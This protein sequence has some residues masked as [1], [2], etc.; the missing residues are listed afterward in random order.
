MSIWKDAVFVGTAGGFLMR[1]DIDV[2]TDE[3]SAIP[4]SVS[5]PSK[6]PT[7]AEKKKWTSSLRPPISIIPEF[8]I[9]RVRIGAEADVRKYHKAKSTAS[10]A[11]LQMCPSLGVIFALAEGHLC[12][13]DMRN[14]QFQQRIQPPTNGSID[15]FAI[16]P[17]AQSSAAANFPAVFP[18]AAS[19]T[20]ATPQNSAFTVIS[21]C[22]C[23]GKRIF[24]LSR[25]T[26][27]TAA[28]WSKQ[29]ELFIPEPAQAV[30][31][32]DAVHV[33]VAFKEEYNVI[34]T[35]TG[36]VV[37]L[38]RIDS[39]VP[40]LHSL[41]G[42]RTLLNIGPKSVVHTMDGA[43]THVLTDAI[44][45]HTAP[46]ALGSTSS[47]ALAVDGAHVHV[48]QKPMPHANILSWRTVQNVSVSNAT[49]LC[50]D[51]GPLVLLAKSSQ[52]YFFQPIRASDKQKDALMLFNIH[53]HFIAPPPMTAPAAPTSAT[54]SAPS[55]LSAGAWTAEEA[56]NS[57]TSHLTS[58]LAGTSHPFMLMIHG[59]VQLFRK[60]AAQKAATAVAQEGEKKGPATSAASP[61]PGPALTA[62]SRSELVE[63]VRN[64]QNYVKGCMRILW[65]ECFNIPTPKPTEEKSKQQSGSS[66]PSADSSIAPD[67]LA[68]CSRLFEE[69]L[70]R[71]LHPLLFPY[72]IAA[73]AT[74]D[75]TFV[76]SCAQYLE[77]HVTPET[78]GSSLLK[79]SLRLNRK[80]SVSQ[81]GSDLDVL[82]SSLPGADTT[83]SPHDLPLP[84]SSSFHPLSPN[85][86]L[87]KAIE[88]TGPLYL[89]PGTPLESTREEPEESPPESPHEDRFTAVGSAPAHLLVTSAIAATA[90]VA[91]SN[92]A[93]APSSAATMT[94]RVLSTLLAD[95]FHPS[96]SLLKLLPA[97]SSPLQ[98]LKLL[99]GVHSQLEYD[100]QNVFDPTRSKLFVMSADE[101]LPIFC[102][103]LVH[104]KLQHAF[105]ESE[106]LGDFLDAD[107]QRG[108]HGYVTTT[109]QIAV[110]QLGNKGRPQQLEQWQE[111]FGDGPAA[112]GETGD[113]S[114]TRPDKA[115][116]FSALTAQAGAANIFSQDKE[117]EKS[118]PMSPLV[119]LISPAPGVVRINNRVPIAASAGSSSAGTGGA[120]STPPPSSSSPPLPQSRFG[121]LSPECGAAEGAN[122]ALASP[123]LQRAGSL[124]SLLP[125]AAGTTTPPPSGLAPSSR[126]IGSGIGSALLSGAS[127][128]SPSRKT[129][130]SF[131][132]SVHASANVGSGAIRT[133]SSPIAVLSTTGPNGGQSFPTAASATP[134]AAVGGATPAVRSLASPS[135]S[136][137][138][139]LVGSEEGKP[140]LAMEMKDL[141]HAGADSGRNPSSGSPPVAALAAATPPTGLDLASKRPSVSAAAATAANPNTLIGRS[142]NMLLS[143]ATKAAAAQAAAA[144]NGGTTQN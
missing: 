37:F 47:F 71:R 127:I 125:S 19:S 101:L 63:L 82:S 119:P 24:L 45:Y 2:W 29:Q 120:F 109:F 94:P 115:T 107:A 100:A 66:S 18:S 112:D 88:R 128:G 35:V 92:H 86:L 136:S 135:N 91:M 113:A 118:E 21:L 95:T 41:G 68:V 13:Y 116:L 23:M 102:Y 131:S 93:R 65:P 59:F 72:Y 85:P 132:F 77:T 83:G 14:F 9:S 139:W 75:A 143:M 99:T 33:L 40:L 111:E 8:T 5:D 126:R 114:R 62:E 130:E 31:W 58:L 12:I 61:S 46:R 133:A 110:H 74:D 96:I 4:S 50:S 51:G 67:F 138:S 97:V 129:R 6:P 80:L 90:P 17:P 48:Y 32:I 39:G 57:L 38:C 34:S 121:A 89:A 49:V 81:S 123:P 60:E 87:A 70:F 22:L 106:M 36:D 15:L 56:T 11:D 122:P 137:S 53:N 144:A 103:V 134:T 26:D 27:S 104:A 52:I 43:D 30:A 1:Y 55:S 10:I 64:F 44:V 78:F 117:S 69:A 105:A 25:S 73:C 124:G 3:R 76:D 108:L 7:P 79:R 98:K 140:V 28:T 16:F 54:P 141:Q 20:A 42:G 142:A 84:K